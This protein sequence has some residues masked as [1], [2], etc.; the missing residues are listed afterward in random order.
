MVCIFFLVQILAEPLIF[1]VLANAVALDLREVS[2]CIHQGKSEATHPT[3]VKRVFLLTY[4]FQLQTFLT[5]E[6]IQ[7]LS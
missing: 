4:H 3:N 2:R 1:T 6:Q 5:D 7:L